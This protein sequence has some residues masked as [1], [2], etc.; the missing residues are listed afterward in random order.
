MG[1]LYLYHYLLWFDFE[2]SRINLII[3]DNL[4]WWDVLERGWRFFCKITR[5][6]VPAGS[7]FYTQRESSECSTF[8]TCLS[9]SSLWWNER[10]FWY[11]CNLHTS[12]SVTDIWTCVAIVTLQ[13]LLTFYKPKG[14]VH[15]QV[16]S[17]KKWRSAHTLIIYCIFISEQTENS[18]YLM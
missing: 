4:E 1:L 7:T 9:T 2:V 5:R 18:V 10:H 17:L 3:S 16:L 14:C 8:L 12:E 15:K 6:H 11:S 13:S